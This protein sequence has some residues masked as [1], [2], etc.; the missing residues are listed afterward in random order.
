MLTITDQFQHDQRDQGNGFRIIETQAA[1]ET[2]LCQLAGG[3]KHQLVGFMRGKM[4]WCLLWFWG[5][6]GTTNRK[7]CQI[8]GKP[9]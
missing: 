2:A 5:N 6:T 8:L 3:Y 4:Q 9:L 1:C 7:A